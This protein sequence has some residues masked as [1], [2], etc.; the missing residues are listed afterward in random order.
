MNRKPACTMRDVAAHLG[1]SHATVSRALRSDPRITEAVR[2][3]VVK[4]ANSLGYKRDPRLAALMS[5]VRATKARAFQGTLAWITDH[6]IRLE[7]ELAPHELYWLPAVTRAEH[8]GYKL[9]RFTN[10][11]PSDSGRIERQLRARGIQGVVIQQ[12]KAPFDLS[13][14]KL[15]WR[16]LATIHNGSSQITQA[17]DSVDAD[18]IGNCVQVFH[19]LAKSGHRRI[20]I[21]TT[22]DIETA[23]NYSLCV[24]WRRF[25][26]LHP[27]HPDVPPCLLP[28][29]GPSSAKIVKRWLTRHRVD[30]V[31]S[32][33]RGMKELLESQGHRL[34]LDLSLAYQGINPH[35][36][37][38]GIWQREDVIAEALIESV[39]ASVEQGR[40]G[41][42]AIP[43]LTLIPG[44]WHPGTTC[45]TT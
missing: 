5:H 11:R 34:P 15:D 20:G 37:N 32:Q 44:T 39:I 42:P 24:G 3:T 45:K 10:A 12:F 16:R 13:E 36:T 40:L 9:E 19:N 30:A 41:L 26:L 29:L 1:I 28:N 17:L 4:A 2:L 43:R 33:V 27:G 21:C 25:Q 23:T 22:H 7:A 35:G 6:D 38:S 18:D 14:W 31:A 8:L